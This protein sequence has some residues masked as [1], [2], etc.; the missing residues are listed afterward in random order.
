MLEIVL[1]T[2]SATASESFS[3]FQTP[4]RPAAAAAAAAPSAI[5]VRSMARTPASVRRGAPAR[6]AE[7]EVA[8]EDEEKIEALAAVTP[9]DPASL[10]REAN[11]LCRLFVAEDR[12]AAARRLVATLARLRENAA[13]SHEA[14]V[15]KERESECWRHYVEAR[16]AFEAWRRLAVA[17]AS[18]D[19]DAAE[20][21]PAL[22]PQ[23]ATALLGA[24]LFPGG[25]LRDVA[26]RPGAPDSP[27]R[28][29]SLDLLRPKCVAQLLFHLAD[30][31]ESVRPEQ[32]D[33]AVVVTSERFALYRELSQAERLQ[34]LQRVADIEVRRGV[35]EIEAR[36]AP[37][38]AR[39]A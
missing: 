4:A 39:D 38:A 34:L 30:V 36:H 8:A 13:G 37:Y 29:P 35:R 20:R 22:A 6:D 14:L 31:S 1:H 23:V 12:F 27:R 21:A 9:D 24:L 5:S 32:L 11:F 7:E 18:G 26:P 28:E 3:F 25:F 10:L 15:N 33:V 19:E 2:P 17:A 16:N